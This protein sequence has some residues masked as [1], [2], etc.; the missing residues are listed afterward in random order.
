MKDGVVWDSLIHLWNDWY[1][2]YYHVDYPRLMIRFEDVLFH[3]KEV[4][5]MVCKCAGAQQPSRFTYLVDEAKWDHKHAQNNMVSA[6]VKYGTDSRRYQNMTR[7]DLEFTHA[8]LNHDLINVFGYQAH[9]MDQ[10]T[11]DSDS[12]CFPHNSKAWL[13]G[14][15]RIG[16]VPLTGV[17]A[18]TAI[19]DHP[20]LEPSNWQPILQQ[21]LC[22]KQSLLL[23]NEEVSNE[24]SESA[25]FAWTV[26]L[27]YLAIH[28][29]QH[30]NALQ[31][32]LERRKQATEQCVNELLVKGIGSFDYECKQS[33]FLIGAL[34]S[35]GLGSVMRI[36]AVNFMLGG[37]ASNRTVLFVNNVEDLDNV[38]NRLYP[39]WQ[40][41]SCERKDHQCFYQ[42]MSP[43]VVTKEDLAGAYIVEGG[44]NRELTRLAKHEKHRVIIAAVGSDFVQVPGN[45]PGY[46]RDIANT[47]IDG[48]PKEDPRIPI[49]RLAAEAILDVDKHN[50]GDDYNGSESVIKRAILMYVMRP[51]YEQADKLESIMKD[52]APDDFNY[53]V[54]LGLPI[55]GTYR[56]NGCLKIGEKI[57]TFGR[58]LFF[59]QP[60][61]SA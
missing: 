15:T 55:R 58:S 50:S 21:S 22:H 32:A 43:C 42:P 18:D 54:A 16:N 8:A 10:N 36:D 26:R 20:L 56:W 24:E 53:S 23:K 61:T 44:A 31:E 47:L 14:T 1:E 45:V 49:L 12:R 30:R 25:I 46:L 52:V 34:P 40:L 4:M 48:L 39:P 27:I 29:H 5:D 33:K 28:H 37:L 19:N 11:A 38:K 3:G 35:R 9:P 17:Q 7:E 41:V 6:M 13:E 2:S 51:S 60:P 57:A 59:S